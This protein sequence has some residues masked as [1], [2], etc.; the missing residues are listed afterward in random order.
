METY[1]DRAGE[2]T[3]RL[4]Y[5]W[6]M[7]LGLAVLAVIGGGIYWLFREVNVNEMDTQLF[8]VCYTMGAVGALVSV[9]GRMTGGSN[10]TID[11]EVGRPALRR[12]GSFRPIIG[13]IFAIV[14]YFSLRGGLIQIE[15]GEGSHTA[16]FYGALAFA[17]GFSERRTQILSGGAARFLNEDEDEEDQPKRTHHASK[18]RRVAHGSRN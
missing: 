11:Y 15:T 13:A 1:Y 4:I 3:G 7:M 17:A 16:F 9:L 2:K 18:R 14:L 10:F 5:F 6:G 12:I 8:F